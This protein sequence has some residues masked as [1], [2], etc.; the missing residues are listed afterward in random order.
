MQFIFVKNVIKRILNTK[1][2]ALMFVMNILKNAART[3]VRTIDKIR[4]IPKINICKFIE[5]KELKNL[6]M[7]KNSEE[8]MHMIKFNNLITLLQ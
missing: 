4:I 1:K 7:H 5:I 6:C 3:V 2:H 8:K